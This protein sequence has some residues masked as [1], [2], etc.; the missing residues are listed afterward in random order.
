MY[1]RDPGQVEGTADVKK[2]PRRREAHGRENT[3]EVRRG[4][5]GGEPLR[6]PRIGK[7]GSRDATVAPWLRRQPF[8]A[9][10]SVASFLA[11][12]IESAVGLVTPADILDDDRVAAL[13]GGACEGGVGAACLAVGCANQDRGRG[14]GGFRSVGVRA[15]QRAIAHAGWEVL[16]DD[17]RKFGLIPIRAASRQFAWG[18]GATHSR[19]ADST[20]RQIRGRSG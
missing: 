11:I 17:Q 12:R 14:A 15:K 3:G 6:G 4:L 5:D 7:A 20:A 10:E 19:R 2:M 8:D 16:I 18:P 1:P 9:V 13:H